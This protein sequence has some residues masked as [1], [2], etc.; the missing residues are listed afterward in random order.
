[1][2]ANRPMPA[3]EG[4]TKEKRVTQFILKE[5]PYGKT[6]DYDLQHKIRIFIES[7]LNSKE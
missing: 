4:N 2:A 6:V 5:L 1:L 7:E 3:Y